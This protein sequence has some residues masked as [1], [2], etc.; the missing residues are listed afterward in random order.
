LAAFVDYE[1]V[2]C[3]LAGVCGHV[4]PLGGED[5]GEPWRGAGKRRAACL[6][7][8][9]GS[10]PRPRSN[11]SRDRE[12][13][14]HRREG[15]PRWK[16]MGFAALNPPY[17]L[18][19]ALGADRSGPVRPGEAAEKSHK[20]VHLAPGRGTM[21]SDGATGEPGKVIW[22]MSVKSVYPAGRGAVQ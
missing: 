21:P 9:L 8:R 11:P 7:A 4:E 10:A 17:L 18:P 2:V 15:A 22:E 16:M 20:R 1:N 5:G 14:G 13:A 3:E 19:P 6:R 12:G